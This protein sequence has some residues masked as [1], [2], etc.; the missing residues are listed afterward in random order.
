MSVVVK[1]I[2]DP[3]ARRERPS[4]LV[5]IEGTYVLNN[6]NETVRLQSERRLNERGETLHGT[7]NDRK[8]RTLFGQLIGRVIARK[9]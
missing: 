3:T 1:T 4:S 2:Q 8:Q 6:L 9:K 7:L 5:G